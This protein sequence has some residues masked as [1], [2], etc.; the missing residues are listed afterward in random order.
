MADPPART[1]ARATDCEARQVRSS[2]EAVERSR[3]LLL[4]TR[5]LV[6]KVVGGSWIGARH[7][8]PGE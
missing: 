7:S 6:G 3:Q 1:V 5:A 4:W 8:P 2:R